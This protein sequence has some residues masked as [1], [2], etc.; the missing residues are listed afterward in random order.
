MKIITFIL[1]FLVFLQSYYFT[2][3][4]KKNET[5]IRKFDETTLAV[6]YYREKYLEIIEQANSLENRL[7]EIGAMLSAKELEHSELINLNSQHLI[8]INLLKDK[9]SSQEILLNQKDN[10]I[11]L[12]K[13]E[14]LKFYEK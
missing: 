8:S 13:N 1:L 14:L 2:K 12:L 5:L 3:L 6:E 9:N 10:E 11:M 4:Y 7:K